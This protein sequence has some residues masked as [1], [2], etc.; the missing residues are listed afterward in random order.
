MSAG[1]ASAR[2]RAHGTIRRAPPVG[3]ERPGQARAPPAPPERPARPRAHREPVARGRTDTGKEPQ[4]PESG[5]PVARVVGPFQDGE[6]V[7][8]VRGFEKLETPV[9]DERNAAACELELER[10]AMARAPEQHRL[11]FQRASRARALRARDRR[12][13]APVPPRRAS[14]RDAACGRLARSVQRFFVNRSAAS[15]ITA[16]D[17]SR[18]GCVD[19]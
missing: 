6:H 9:L 18:I 1:H 11:R 12:R 15:P 17:A 19:R 8:H 10:S 14:R 5:H 2:R 3:C 16:F 13:N 4:R 7:L